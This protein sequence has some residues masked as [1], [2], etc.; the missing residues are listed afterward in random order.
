MEEGERLVS[1]AAARLLKFLKHARRWRHR[2]ARARRVILS[3]SFTEDGTTSVQHRT[4]L[5]L[6]RLI[7]GCDQPR[8]I[9]PRPG[10]KIAGQS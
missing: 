9:M 5:G 6:R 8:A 3:G 7:Q 10:D 2:P 1:N 4:G